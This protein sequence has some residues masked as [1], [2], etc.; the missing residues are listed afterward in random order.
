MDR[1]EPNEEVVDSHCVRRSGSP[2]SHDLDS[3]YNIFQ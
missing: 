3:L 1:T 2:R